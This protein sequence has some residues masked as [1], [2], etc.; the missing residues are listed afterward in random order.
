[1]R[2]ALVEYEDEVEFM[3]ESPDVDR[4]KVKWIALSPFA[5]VELQKRN[6][7]FEIIERYF[8][9]EELWDFTGM[10]TYGTANELI[11][12]VDA[13]LKAENPEFRK[14]DIDVLNCYK[15]YL[16]RLFDG[17][18]GRIFM[19][20]S[21]IAVLRPEGVYVC[22][23][24]PPPSMERTPFSP[25]EKLW[26]EI[27]SA[28]NWDIEV[29]FLDMPFQEGR[30]KEPVSPLR[31]FK[32]AVQYFPRLWNL[33]HFIKNVSLK[34]GL[35]L[36]VKNCL[37]RDN[38]L[39]L[40]PLYDWQYAMPILLKN[41]NGVRYIESYHPPSKGSLPSGVRLPEGDDEYRRLF[42][43]GGVNCYPIMKKRIERI[44]AEGAGLFLYRHKKIVRYLRKNNIRAVGFSV[45][46]D[47]PLWMIAQ[48]AKKLGIP[49]IVWSHNFDPCDK[50]KISG[51]EM[52]Y[53]DYVFLQGEG[54]KKLYE[55]LHEEYVF[56]AVPV[57]S[58]KI[59]L[60]GLTTG[61]SEYILYPTVIYFQNNLYFQ[62]RPPFH[63][64]NNIYPIQKVF[65]DYLNTV[66]DT[67]VVFKI[68]PYVSYRVPPVEITNPRIKTI[69]HEKT[70]IDLLSGAKAV[71]LDYCMTNTLYESISTEKPVFVLNKIYP[72][73][74]EA[75]SLLRKR[76]VVSDDPVELVR[77]LDE[78]LT[79]GRYPAD[80]ANRDFLKY[81][82]T[83]KD[84][85][86]SAYRAA[87]E[88]IRLMQK[89]G[90]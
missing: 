41:G 44:F 82:A 31:A 90:T 6:I 84:D 61:A 19:L 39:F 23:T 24:A 69:R 62:R 38:I 21:L 58:E 32:K 65:I 9:E 73:P 74:E 75:V 27:L 30:P 8:D 20:R 85:G 87:K 16:M 46:A 3:L 81:Y 40:G 78:F 48:I 34:L 64:S 51:E 63:L 50:R 4:E 86:Q 1:M 88:T 33:A 76:A 67:D 22:R 57:G 66:K 53:T 55:E 2:L 13:R 11:R 54:H 72:L 29:F 42:V 59:R 71:I 26:A 43:I 56:T 49:T 47:G 83:Y 15:F 18:A 77:R 60:T 17:I 79:M 70:F 28:D 45:L 12:V 80:V 52:L 68:Y 25:G 37:L 5:A 7:P 89:R 10:R 36:S 14:A 35:P